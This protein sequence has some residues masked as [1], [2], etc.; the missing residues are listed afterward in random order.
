MLLRAPPGGG[1]A[2]HE[3]EAAAA[4]ARR[5]RGERSERSARA[6]RET[7]GATAR[8]YHHAAEPPRVGDEGGAP[9]PRST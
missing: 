9:A 6:E 5:A 7:M 2:P 4:S 3:A 8:F 1:A